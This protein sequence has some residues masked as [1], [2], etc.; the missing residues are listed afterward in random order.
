M[1]WKWT[2]DFPS[3]QTVVLLSQIAVGF[4]SGVKAS[5]G[6]SAASEVKPV[7]L[8]GCSRIR[9]KLAA[10]HPV[11]L[12]AGE[13]VSAGQLRWD[14]WAHRDPWPQHSLP[15]LT[16]SCATPSRV[17]FSDFSESAAQRDVSLMSDSS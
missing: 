15:S 14:C 2:D 9:C 10:V 11:P 5:E 7:L 4:L 1:G 16:G 8:G 13:Y 17:P 6:H 3:F 12:P